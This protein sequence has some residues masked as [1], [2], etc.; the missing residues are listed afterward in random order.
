MTYYSKERQVVKATCKKFGITRK[1]LRK[2]E[3]QVRHKN[4]A[5]KVK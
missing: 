3:K 2:I 5:D 1:Q 4:A